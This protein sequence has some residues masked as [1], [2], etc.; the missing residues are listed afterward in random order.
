MEAM[1][2][3]IVILNY[4]TPQLTVDCLHSLAKVRHEVDGT[5]VM[6]LDNGSGDDSPR[7]I[8][9]AIAAN[10]WGEWA[11]LRL[12]EKNL[13]FAGGNNVALAELMRGD[14]QD[15]DYFLLLNS[16]TRVEPRTLGHCRAMME[17]APRIGM[18]SC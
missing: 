14:Q 2:L 10:G 6:V 12:L 16:D 11:T 13:G 17:Q 8:A 5:R 4:R 1:G 18:M 7:R 9:E 15:V 3:L